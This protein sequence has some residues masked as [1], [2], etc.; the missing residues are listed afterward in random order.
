MQPERWSSLCS[1]KHL[2]QGQEIKR[3]GWELEREC[4]LAWGPPMP[5]F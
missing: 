1:Q 5:E 3:V 2:H 4:C